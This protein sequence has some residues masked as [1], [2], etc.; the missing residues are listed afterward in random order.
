MFALFLCVSLLSLPVF[1]LFFAKD[2][3]YT[4][5]ARVGFPLAYVGT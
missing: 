4:S 3:M 2:V 5:H 1:S